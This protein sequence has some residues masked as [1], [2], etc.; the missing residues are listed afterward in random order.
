MIKKTR[1]PRKLKDNN[2]VKNYRFNI[3]LNKEEY[4]KVKEF[5][6]LKNIGISEFFRK[7]VNNVINF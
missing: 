7:I 4:I 6:Q 5:C 2:L 3:Y 1:K